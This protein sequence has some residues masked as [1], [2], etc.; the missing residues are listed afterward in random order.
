MVSGFT[1]LQNVTD[2]LFENLSL[3]DCNYVLKSTE[4]VFRSGNMY[5]CM[6]FSLLEWVGLGV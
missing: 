4:I 1:D 2:S 6:Y 3:F 5:V